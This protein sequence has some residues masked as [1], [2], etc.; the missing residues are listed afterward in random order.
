MLKKVFSVFVFLILFVS[1]AFAELPEEYKKGK[2]QINKS[3]TEQYKKIAINN[4]EM[5]FSNNGIS[6][7]APDGY[8]GLMFPKNSDQN[9]VYIDGPILSGMVGD[10]VRLIGSTYLSALQPGPSIQGVN[11]VDPRY[12]IYMVRKNWEELNPIDEFISGPG[13]T[14]V[15][16]ERDYNEWPIDMG[17]PYE[18]VNSNKIPKFI[19]DEQA[20]Y[21]MNDFDFLSNQFYGSASCGTEWQALVWAYNESE[22]ALGNV[23]FKKYTIINKGKEPIENAYLSYWS[24]T[25]IGDATNDCAGSDTVLSLGYAYNGGVTDAVYGAVCPAIGYAFIQGPTVKSDNLN[26]VANWNFDKKPG[27]KNLGMT[28]FNFFAFRDTV[29]G[30]ITQ[31]VDIGSYLC[32]VEYYNLIQGYGKNGETRI[33]PQTQEPCKFMF[34]GDPVTRS[35]WVWADGLPPWVPIDM[36]LNYFPR[37]VQITMSS[38]PFRLAVGDTQEVVIGIVVGQGADKLSSITVMKN[39]T[40]LAQKAYDENCSG[41]SVTT[42][43]KPKEI[44]IN[45]SL[46]QNYPNPFNPTTTIQYTIPKD[47]YVKLVVYDVTGKVV[48]ELVNGHKSAGRYNVE[49]NASSYASGIYYYR[50]EAGQYKSV[51]KMMLLK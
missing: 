32:G 9:L 27:Y 45:Y 28:S 7:S 4:L 31:V 33:N 43:N 36:Y 12:R 2:N 10:S 46:S 35:G 3:M 51:Q 8:W 48:K 40:L 22:R 44:P 13:Y 17:A 49:F 34:P 20:W 42:V 38:G 23:I 15:D 47:E 19:G 18:V 37:D 14:K 26:D 24:D 6:S 30:G 5:W 16:Y 1:F 11:P 50:I 41:S 21:V 39:Y 29:G 25:D